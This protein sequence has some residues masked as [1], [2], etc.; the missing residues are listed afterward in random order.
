MSQP[1][2]ETVKAADQRVRAFL[3]DLAGRRSE[4]LTPLSEREP[5]GAQIQLRRGS[6]ETDAL[7][8]QIGF[9]YPSSPDVAFQNFIDQ[10]PMAQERVLLQLV[11]FSRE[12]ASIYDATKWLY[13]EVALSGRLNQLFMS[14]LFRELLAIDRPDDAHGSESGRNALIL[15]LIDILRAEY[16]LAAISGPSAIERKKRAGE[17]INDACEV[18]V[19]VLNDEF[20]QLNLSRSGVRNLWNRHRKQ[21]KEMSEEAWTKWKAT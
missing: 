9:P 14:V 12:I 3:A 18:L 10:S 21:Q 15:N 6:P 1:T 4:A 19:R 13:N 8:T 17:P 5:F 16:G 20:P 11:Q 7:F 2:A